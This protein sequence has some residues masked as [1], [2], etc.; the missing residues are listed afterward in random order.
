[1]IAAGSELSFCVRGQTEA[2]QWQIVFTEAMLAG[3]VA[4][5]LARR[6]TV[7]GLDVRSTDGVL[8]GTLPWS[9]EGTVRVRTRETHARADDVAAIV[10][11]AFYTV[12]G[13]MPTVTPGQC[14]LRFTLPELPS[15]SWPTALVVVGVA[16]VVLAW[17]F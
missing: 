17:K 1:M 3:E 12:A 13:H 4:T 2:A 15:F 11:H 5:E 7:A 14:D 8:T 6:L 16:I 9:Y 10:Q